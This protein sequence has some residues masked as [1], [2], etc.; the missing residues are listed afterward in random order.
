M[1]NYPT[2]LSV[3]ANSP[4][5]NEMTKLCRMID[6]DKKE[7]G[8]SF[9]DDKI[10]G[11]KFMALITECITVW[12]EKYPLTSQRTPSRF[13]AAYADLIADGVTMPREFIYFQNV[14]RRTSIPNYVAEAPQTPSHPVQSIQQYIPAENFS[15]INKEPIGYES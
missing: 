5:L 12:A 7:K 14:D 15:T 10:I 9:G 3:L 4:L 11:G 1:K 8:E 6:P 13:K 2:F